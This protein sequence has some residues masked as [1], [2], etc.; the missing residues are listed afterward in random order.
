MIL[1]TFIFLGI[2]G[3]FIWD[4][5]K[6]PKKFKRL[7]F[8]IIGI[9]YLASTNFYLNLDDRIK[10]ITMVIVALFTIRYSF[11]YYNDYKKE[12]FR[13]IKR[14]RN[15]RDKERI[16][17]DTLLL[18]EIL[19]AK[20]QEIRKKSSSY[21]ITMEFS[22]TSIESP[23]QIAF[24]RLEDAPF[25]DYYLEEEDIET[26]RSSIEILENQIGMFEEK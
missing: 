5:T 11:A 9:S 13:E 19:D 10:L 7:V 16:E 25:E 14:L 6:D 21:E 2:V 8:P 15:I 24:L 26:D 3:F 12:R 17:R 4:Y 1:R 18:K 22:D 20:N 23:R